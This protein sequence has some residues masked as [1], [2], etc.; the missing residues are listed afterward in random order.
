MVEEKKKEGLSI[1]TQKKELNPCFVSLCEVDILPGGV[2][3]HRSLWCYQWHSRPKKQQQSWAVNHIQSGPTTQ[4]INIR[5][6]SRSS[7]HI[8][9]IQRVW[10]CYTWIGHSLSCVTSRNMAWAMLGTRGLRL[11][12]R[13]APTGSPPYRYTSLP[14]SWLSPALI[15]STTAQGMTSNAMQSINTPSV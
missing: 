1:C 13:K 11:G 2:L 14:S 4:N 5:T 8:K 9:V 10:K 6:L 12:W 15:A 7:I 3:T